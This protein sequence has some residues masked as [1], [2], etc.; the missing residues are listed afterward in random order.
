MFCCAGVM[1]PYMGW[2]ILILC[3]FL[4]RII[5][6]IIA[7]IIILRARHL[8]RTSRVKNCLGKDTISGRILAL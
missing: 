8:A 1:G 2:V 6:I 3:R 5:L 4:R 7:S